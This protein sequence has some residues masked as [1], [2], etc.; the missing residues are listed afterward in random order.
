MENTKYGR[1]REFECLSSL[2][3]WFC[4]NGLAIN[5]DKSEAILLFGSWQRLRAFPLLSSFDLAGTAAPHSDTVKTLSV[6]LDSKLTLRLHIT[7]L[8][9]SCFYHNRAIRHIGSAL[10]K[11][12][13]QT[14]ACSLVSSRLDYANSLFLGLSDLEVK[15]LQRIQTA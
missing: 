4:F 9:K 11:N 8:C 13:S 3:A 6:T 12:M 1:R 10:T 14:I 7:N 2:Y 15:R 5:P